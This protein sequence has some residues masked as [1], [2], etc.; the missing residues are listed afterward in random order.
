[1]DLGFVL[2]VVW[3]IECEFSQWF[4]LFHWISLLDGVMSLILDSFP[5]LTIDFMARGL[6][7]SGSCSV[8]NVSTFILADWLLL[9][10][11]LVLVSVI[12]LPSLYILSDLW[13]CDSL[14][15]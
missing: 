13:G 3:V 15:S 4:F 10:R 2:L 12:E 11:E 6:L 5:Q 9:L 14:M 8:P 7:Q 1:M